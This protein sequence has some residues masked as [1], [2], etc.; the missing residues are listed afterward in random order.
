MAR[1][2][3]EATI[4]LEVRDD[5][6]RYAE[7][8]FNG[9]TSAAVEHLLKHGM[10]TERQE[11]RKGMAYATTAATYMLVILAAFL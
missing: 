8:Y 11:A 1:P 3:L 9:N 7:R 6:R 5:V 4:D 10:E 2:R